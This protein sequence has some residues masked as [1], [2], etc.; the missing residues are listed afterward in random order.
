MRRWGS[1]LLFFVILLAIWEVLVRVGVWSPLLVPS[2]LEVGRFF[3]GSIQDRTLIE[4]SVVTLK[5]LLV[6][7]AL[8]ILLGLPLGLLNARF[9]F[10]QDTL[11]MLALGLQTL[12][13]VCWAP[14]AL[15]WFGQTEASM[16]FIVVMGSLWSI[17]LAAESGVKNV[18]PIY[19]RAA[20][21]MG[22]RG[23]AAV[24]CERD[25]TRV[26]VRVAFFDG[27]GNLYHDFDGVW[28]GA[29]A[30]LRAGIACDGC[31]DWDYGGDYWDWLGDG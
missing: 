29:S 1:A 16:L 28:A 18:P 14:L 31:R 12:P 17:T 26:G 9:R 23:V 13:S 21:T 25:E 7:Y 30:A 24:H 20:R 11:G 19:T 3:V 8:S 5:R 6:G 22:S 10:C 4:S 2:P 27:G 15:L